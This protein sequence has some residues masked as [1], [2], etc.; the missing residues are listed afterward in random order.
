MLCVCDCQ[1][2][3]AWSV[4][5]AVVGES[6]ECFGICFVS[7]YVL[8]CFCFFKKT[9]FTLPVWTGKKRGVRLFPGVRV[10]C[11]PAGLAAEM[12]IHHNVVVSQRS[13]EQSRGT[14]EPWQH[15]TGARTKVS[16]EEGKRSA[17]ITVGGGRGGRSPEIEKKKK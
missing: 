9:R 16:S 17:C 11:T 13:R 14:R 12:L 5:R 4:F 1:T 6:G 10:L 7:Y 15:G 2:R 8:F 3:L